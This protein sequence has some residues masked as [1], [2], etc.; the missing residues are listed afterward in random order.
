MPCP[1]TPARRPRRRASIGE[2]FARDAVA[3]LVP[4]IDADVAIA[5]L[6]G[7]ELVLGDGSAMFRF[8]HALVRDA[9][10]ELIADDDRVAAHGH[11]GDYLA[12]SDVADAAVVA[13]HFELGARGADAVRWYRRAADHALAHHDHDNAIAHAQ[14][15]RAWLE[16][17]DVVAATALDQIVAEA[18]LWRGNLVAA[19]D[20]AQHALTQL[21]PGTAEVARRPRA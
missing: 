2:R 9:A 14:H 5:E 8:R 15:A 7:G 11:A 12:A 18:E 19:R 4:R 16:A 13:R 20:A 17:D 6:V 3:A 10:Y 21:Q 1:P